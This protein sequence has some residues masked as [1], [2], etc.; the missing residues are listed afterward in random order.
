MD[1][2][3]DVQLGMEGIHRD[4]DEGLTYRRLFGAR[5]YLHTWVR[6]FTGFLIIAGSYVAVHGVGIRDLPANRLALVGV[7]VLA[8]NAVAWAI[9][10]RYRTPE[11][12]E[13]AYRSLVQIMYGTIVLDYLSLTAAIWLVGGA[14]SP[15][16]AFYLLHVILGCLLLSKRAAVASMTLAYLLLAGLAIFEWQGIIPA[17]TPEGAVVSSAAISGR[18]VLTMLVVYGLL[19]GVTSFLL[20][21]LSGLM[22]CGERELHATS[23]E[24]DRLSKMRRDFL[25]IALHD[26]KAPVGAVSMLLANLHEGYC[27]PVTEQ[28]R[29]A[30]GR[31]RTRLEQLSAFIQDLNL[32]AQLDSQGLKDQAEVVDVGTLLR[33]LADDTSELAAARG[34]TLRAEPPH[35]PMQVRGIRR[36][37]RESV[38]NYITNAIKYTPEGGH[39]TLRAVERDDRVRIEVQDNG[40]GISEADQPSLFDE[41]VRVRTRE[42]KATE[43]TGLGLS[44]VKRVVDGHGGHVYVESK[45]HGG[46]CFGMDLPRADERGRTP[47][48]VRP[49]VMTRDVESGAV[50]SDGP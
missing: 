36:L 45:L 46:S 17:I 21:G 43:G 15:F 26:L 25:H 27:G 14:R 6:L 12:S 22:R 7:I 49:F 40:V 42:T 28:Q 5:L 30:L 13:L 1:M 3:R 8:Y 35:R 34:Q 20:I 38:L 10:R 41:F 23:H 4:C 2:P 11:E 48:G 44:I 18:Y 19:F 37:L 39:I 47:Q 33:E 50:T 31:C 16:V 29:N 32:L 9:S 24:L